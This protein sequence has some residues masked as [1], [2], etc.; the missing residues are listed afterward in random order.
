M[1]RVLSK[2]APAIITI[3]SLILA[4]FAFSAPL[5]AEG[6]KNNMQQVVE[7]MQP[8]WNLGNT[9]DATGTETS[10]GNPAVTQQLIKAIAAQGYHSVRMPITW[11]QRL[12]SGPDYTIDETFMQRIEEIVGWCLDENLYV[13]I[14]LHHDSNWI[15]KMESDHDAVLAKY[16]AVWKQIAARFKNTSDKLLFESVNEPRFSEDWGKDSPVYFDMLGELNESFYYIVRKSGGVNGHRPLVLPTITASPSQARLDELYNTMT[17]LDDPNLIATIHY[18]GFYP[19]SV[20]VAGNVSFDETAKRD[21]EQTFDRAYDTFVERG[22]PVI[23]GEFGLLG[24]DKFVDTIEHG[25]VLKYLEYL[26]YYGQQKKLTLMLWDNGQH[27]DRNALQWHNPDFYE[28]MSAGLSGRSSNAESDSVYIRQGDENKD[29]SLRLN[30]NGNA[31][32]EIRAGDRVLKAGIDYEFN[33][34]RLNLKSDLLKTLVTEQLGDNAVLTCVFSSGANWSIHVI[35]YA[36][37]TLSGAKGIRSSFDIPTQFNGDR[38]TT[39]E[40]LYATGGNAGPD[41]WTPYKEFGKAFLPKRESNLVTLPSAFFDQVKDGEVLLRLHFGSGNVIEYKLTIEGNQVTGTAKDDEVAPTASAVPT[42]DEPDSPSVLP[43][44]DPPVSDAGTGSD[45]KTSNDNVL[46]Y[47]LD[48][49]V[50]SAAVVLLTV[51][52]RK[53]W[54]SR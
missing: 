25:E 28:V 2:R 16:N 33:G 54:R 26:T 52:M 20:N 6:V 44:A 24:F 5:Q 39:M 19:F 32:V 38:L 17:K 3:G 48:G 34:D 18:Y 4:I 49:I 12:G 9:F 29:A 37:P 45:A 51:A 1:K 41:D 27:F 7:A 15:G 21:V 50:A 22:I 31:L 23:V 43:S 35:H 53:R 40:A 46:G 8:G 11:N 10:W 42:D 47:L 14:N 30:L 13:I 36:V